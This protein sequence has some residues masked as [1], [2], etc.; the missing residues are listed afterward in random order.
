MACFRGPAALVLLVR[1][2]K[3]R[4][5]LEPFTKAQRTEQA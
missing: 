4:D 2:S 1:C 3:G 5:S